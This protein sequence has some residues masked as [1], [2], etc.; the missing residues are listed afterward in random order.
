MTP[1]DLG[2]I[3][4]A[5]VVKKRSYLKHIFDGVE[6]K[7]VLNQAIINA[8][9]IL[10]QNSGDDAAKKLTNYIRLYFRNDTFEYPENDR[11]SLKSSIEHTVSILKK[12][13]DKIDFSIKAKKP[14]SGFNRFIHRS[15]AALASRIQKIDDLE[16]RKRNLEI[17]IYEINHAFFKHKY[18]I[19]DIIK[20][21]LG[22]I[23]TELGIADG[24]ISIREGEISFP[25][26]SGVSITLEIKT[27][28]NF[29]SNVYNQFDRQTKALDNIYIA[30]LKKRIILLRKRLSTVKK[31][32]TRYEYISRARSNI[33]RYI[34]NFDDDFIAL[35][36]NY[37]PLLKDD[38]AM[39]YKKNQYQ[40]KIALRNRTN[41]NYQLALLSSLKG[42][43]KD[44]VIYLH[45]LKDGGIGYTLN[46]PRNIIHKGKITRNDFRNGVT[47]PD[48]NR[49]NK[50]VTTKQ[51]IIE[52]IAKHGKICKQSLTHLK[53][54]ITDAQ[55]I[56]NDIENEMINQMQPS[57]YQSWAKL[58]LTISLLTG[59]RI[60]EVCVTGRFEKIKNNTRKM[61]M[62]GIAKQK[63]DDDRKNKSVEFKTFANATLIMQAIN[64]L[65]TI[66]DFSI[67]GCEYRKFEKATNT[68]LRSALVPQR[69]NQ[70][71]MID[72]PRITIKLLP[73]SMRQ[74]YAAM[75]K[76]MLKIRQP[77]ESDN[78]YDYELAKHLGHNAE[79]DMLTVQS[80]KDI[81]IYKQE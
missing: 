36:E 19:Q 56:F 57:R 59:R 11:Y 10:N 33:A 23:S 15:V 74:L 81:V 26:A 77:N 25:Q 43:P 51:E 22:K 5:E 46:T 9:C 49:I 21:A 34:K 54:N 12:W 31:Y 17:A 72:H 73:R 4:A 66:K 76:Y 45:K 71:P 64:T 2:K 24:I 67:Y 20:K 69:Q 50:L 28:N 38:Q 75:L 3:I 35:V 48:L 39:Q 79:K 27:I 62:T 60:Y 8:L 44:N 53:L 68:T 78:F 55:D 61:K 40:T 14:V 7:K 70:I 63:N 37:L 32:T 1:Y 30:Q 18:V 6:S 47:I 16:L 29:I 58:C 42:K 65:R 41:D 80:Y 13:A 52:I